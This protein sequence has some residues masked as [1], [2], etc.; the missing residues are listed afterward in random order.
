MSDFL[1]W[2][3]LNYSVTFLICIYVFLVLVVFNTIMNQ[4]HLYHVLKNLIEKDKAFEWINIL[5]VL[6]TLIRVPPKGLSGPSPP[7]LFILPSPLTP[8]FSRRKPRSLRRG[9]S[10]IRKETE[11]SPFYDK[12]GSMAVL[13]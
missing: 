12:S 1:K 10:L 4:I 9:P 5:M 8:P 7:P 3:I 2:L 6:V 11:E 13:H